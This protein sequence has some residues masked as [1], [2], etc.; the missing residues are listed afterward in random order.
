VEE[1]KEK[2]YLHGSAIKISIFLNI[3]NVHVNRVPVAGEIEYLHYQPGEFLPAFKSHASEINERNYVGIRC[4]HNP[5]V[6]VLVVQITG[7]IARRIVC[8]AKTG[9]KLQTGDLFGM[10]KFGSCTEIYLPLGTTVLVE[11]GQNVRGG[12]TIIGKF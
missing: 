11:K 10:I 1:V 2:K 3:F 4:K 7:F 5:N 12:E 6:V 9:D 8:W